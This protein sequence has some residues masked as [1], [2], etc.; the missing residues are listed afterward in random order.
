EMA[1]V[2][3]CIPAFRPDLEPG[4]TPAEAD[5]DTILGI[6]GGRDERILS[7]LLLDGDQVPEAGTEVT[8]QGAIAGTLR[9]CV[10]SFGLNATIGLG[11]I[12]TQRAQPG[13]QFTI[14]ESTATVVAKPFYRRRS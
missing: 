12:D 13:R 11:I 3:S 8:A 6:E 2:E 7:A 1:R 14:G 5:L 9:S 4:L 10:R